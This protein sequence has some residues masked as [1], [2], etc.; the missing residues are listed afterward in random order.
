M[1]LEDHQVGQETLVTVKRGLKETHLPQLW[2]ALR[3]NL[4]QVLKL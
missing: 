4:I 3:S 1:I 2:E